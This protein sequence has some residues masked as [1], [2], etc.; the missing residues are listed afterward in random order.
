MKQGTL[1]FASKSKQQ[2]NS[3]PKQRQ[4]TLAFGKPASAQAKPKSPTND[5]GNSQNASKKRTTAQMTPSAAATEEPVADAAVASKTTKGSK[6]LR[7][8]RDIEEEVKEVATVQE[9]D[10][11][12]RSESP[13]EEV[14]GAAAASKSKKTPAKSP[15]KAKKTA[16]PEQTPIELSTEPYKDLADLCDLQSS[17][18][19]PIKDAP[20]HSG[21]P[22]PFGFVANA[23]TQIENCSGKNSQN[24]VKEIIANVFRAAIAVN[25][26]ELVN[27]FYFFIVKLAPE[28]EGKETGV[29][30][31]LV[32]KSVAKSCGKTP[33]Q[34]RDAF[35]E[36]GDL[37]AVISVGKK[38]QNTLGSFFGAASTKK[39]PKLLFKNVFGTF[40]RISEMS[41]NSSV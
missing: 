2:D 9:P 3:T 38:T 30:Q 32:L 24:I 26:D 13:E 36:E 34:I 33:K 19:D 4:G 28:Y 10:T 23:L 41:G 17:D 5:T 21:Q 29:G 39:K 37:G 8:T 22:M 15:T 14:K 31:E 1:A 20:H 6:R 40:L 12:M 11:K 35:K 7:R 25:P 18:F 16:N 27:L